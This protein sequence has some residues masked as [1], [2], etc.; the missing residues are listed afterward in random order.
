MQFIEKVK[1][2]LKPRGKN[3]FFS[4]LPENCRVLDVGCGNDSPRLFK[5]AVPDGHYTGIDVSDYRQTGPVLADE[6]I[7]TSPEKFSETIK[8][9][10][11]QFDA[12]ISSHNLEHCYDRE[13][14]VEAMVHVLKPGGYLYL[15]FPSAASVNFPRR[16]G[17]LNYF[18]D[19]T[20]IGLPPEVDKIVAALE[21][22]GA[23]VVFRTERYRPFLMATVGL[24]HEP[25]SRYTS[26]VALGT[27]EYFG[28]E[29][30]IWVKKTTF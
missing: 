23:H 9:L 24:L 17:T 13:A 19:E 26:K 27:W 4:R 20:H 1:Q 28:F 12:V 3:A 29:A 16:Q 11:A 30:I 15:S 2:V 25:Y 18:E 14:T 7:I 8:N 22:N 10:P 6:Y 21:Q 5:S